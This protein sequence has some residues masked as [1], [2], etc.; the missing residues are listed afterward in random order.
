MIDKLDIR[1]FDNISIQTI[2]KR[3]KELDLVYEIKRIGVRKEWCIS[4]EL[5]KNKAVYFPLAYQSSKY[6]NRLYSNP[7]KFF[8]FIPYHNFLEDLIGQKAIDNS[9]IT[10]LDFSVDLKLSFEDI[11]KGVSIAYKRNAKLHIDQGSI[12]EGIYFGKGDEVIVIYNKAKKLGKAYTGTTPLTRIE[13]RLKGS[14]LPI[15]LMNEVP[16]LFGNIHSGLYNPFERIGISEYSF[17]P[18]DSLK[19]FKEAYRLGE[20]EVL[21]R[22]MSFQVARK[23][24]NKNKN[25]K[26][27]YGKLYKC[28]G[29]PIELSEPFKENIL[30]FFNWGEI[31]NENQQL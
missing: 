19:T 17:P 26:R 3:A 28:K 9:N 2:K 10:R 31:N 1:L 11:V 30:S 14:K 7:S 18:I 16:T 20:L 13:I 24:L 4:V 6:T 8:L 25:F 21:A 22:E 15:E 27:D 23:R 29:I 12:N 5:E